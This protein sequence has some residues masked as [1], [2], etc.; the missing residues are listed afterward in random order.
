MNKSPL[1]SI[2][3]VKLISYYTCLAALNPFSKTRKANILSTLL[4]QQTSRLTISLQQI[5][6]PSLPLSLINTHHLS[7][8]ATLYTLFSLTS[9]PT[10]VSIYLIH[11]IPLSLSH[12]HTTY[13]SLIHT[14]PISLSFTHYLLLL[15]T[16]IFFFKH[17]NAFYLYISLSLSLTH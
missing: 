16:V 7:L 17:M 4:L 11:T 1:V 14:L 2:G 10:T 13:L 9:T 8:F 6:I 15:T 12:T 3:K 5:H